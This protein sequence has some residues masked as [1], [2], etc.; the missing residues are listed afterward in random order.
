[1]YIYRFVILFIGEMAVTVF[2]LIIVQF[3]YFLIFYLIGTIKYKKRLQ[4][5]LKTI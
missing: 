2:F 5:R 3:I 4:G 1:M